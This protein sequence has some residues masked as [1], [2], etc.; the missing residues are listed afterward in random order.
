MSTGVGFMPRGAVAV[1]FPETTGTKFRVVFTG[2]YGSATLQLAEIDLSGA[3]RLESFVEKQLGKMHPTP[4]PMWDTY[5]WPTQAE[6]ERSR[7]DRS[8]G[9]RARSELARGAPTAR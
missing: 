2:G 5:L 3:A 9:R 7:V 6:P 4:L 8:G 1:S